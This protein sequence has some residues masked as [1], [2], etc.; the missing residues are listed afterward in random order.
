MDNIFNLEILEKLGNHHKNLMLLL[1][2]NLDNFFSDKDIYK[3]I[4]DYYNNNKLIKAFP[5]GIS[6]NQVIAHNSYHHNNIIYLKIGDFIKI[7]FGLIENGNIIDGARTFIYKSSDNNLTKPILDCKEIVFKIEDFIRKNIQENGKV[8]IQKISV[9]TNALIVSKG[10]NSIGLLGGHTIELNKVHG[11]KL[12]L[13]KPL[14]LLPEQ[15]LKFIDPLDEIGQE[16]MFA[17][18]VYIPEIKSD[19][20]M[21]QSLNIPTTHYELDLTNTNIILKLN[22]KLKKIIEEIKKETLGMVYEYHIHKKFSDIEINNLI[23]LGI[24]KKHYPLEFKTIDNKII[25][26]VQYEDCYLV[27]NGNLINLTR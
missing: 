5:V 27:R 20:D 9:L 25:K 6:I 3:Y 8:L 7:D 2:Q 26:Y 15:A 19:G 10:Y 1:E 18:E 16:E 24:I 23:S 11:S 4:S 14:K 17:I 22:S 13:N 21:I 12:I